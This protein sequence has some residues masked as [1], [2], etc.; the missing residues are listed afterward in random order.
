MH[1]HWLASFGRVVGVP[2]AGGISTTL[3]DPSRGWWVREEEASFERTLMALAVLL[4]F[5]EVSLQMDAMGMENHR[6]GRSKLRITA[7]G[8]ELSAPFS[9]ILQHVS[10]V[11]PLVPIARLLTSVMAA[12]LTNS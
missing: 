3:N 1:D 11:P 4:I 5:F 9:E 8:C 12:H 2:L 10:Q 6:L 7:P